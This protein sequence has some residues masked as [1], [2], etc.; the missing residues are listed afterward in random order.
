[1]SR[2]KKDSRNFTCKMN[3]ETYNKLDE[4]CLVSG[5]S[6]TAVVER[7]INGFVDASLESMKELKI[8]VK[9]KL[10]SEV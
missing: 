4:Y 2:E 3:T 8:R 1:M 5:L 10:S 9:E 7:A 6:K